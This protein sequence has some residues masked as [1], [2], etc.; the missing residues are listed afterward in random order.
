MNEIVRVTTVVAVD[1][2]TAFDIFTGEIG[3]WWKPK[4]DLFR[5]GRTGLMRFEGDRLVE[6]YDSGDAFEVGRV[7]EWKP[8]ENLRFEWRQGDFVAGD[9]TEVDVRFEPATHGTRVTIE[10]RG[11]DRIAPGH[12]ARHGYT[13]EAFVS[14]V[15]LR[16]ADL[17]TAYRRRAARMS[18]AAG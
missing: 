17:L 3:I 8:G 2:A 15:G 4:V 7:L 5:E 14:M 9:I 11:W 18:R 13:G 10:H 6:A 12:P 16:W 1:P